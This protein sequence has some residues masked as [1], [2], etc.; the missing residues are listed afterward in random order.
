MERNVKCCVRPPLLTSIGVIRIHS[1]VWPGETE[2]PNFV[3][4][5]RVTVFG[6]KLR[7]PVV[8][9]GVVV[10]RRSQSEWLRYLE[11]GLTLNHQIFCG[12]PCQHALQ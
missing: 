1:G 5:V 3:S 2:M 10:G 7:G 4:F 11:N 9:A 12:H 8:S 6:K